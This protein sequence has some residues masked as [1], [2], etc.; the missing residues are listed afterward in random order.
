MEVLGISGGIFGVDWGRVWV[1]GFEMVWASWVTRRRDDRRE[2]FAWKGRRRR[3][4]KSSAAVLTIPDSA[5]VRV[6]VWERRIE[7][8]PAVSACPWLLL[9]GYGDSLVA[10]FR[11]LS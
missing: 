5:A 7:K 3:W 2:V 9:R 4:R 11:A 10:N 6:W 8:S 1:W